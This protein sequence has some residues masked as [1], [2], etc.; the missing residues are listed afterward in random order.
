VIAVSVV[1]A[2]RERSAFLARALASLEA[3][4]S[5]P[6]FEVVVADNGS[7]DGTGAVVAAALA[8]DVLA[9]Q[10]VVVPEPSRAAARNAGI[11]AARGNLVLFVDDDVS[12]PTHFVAAH[13]AAHGRDPFP[14]VVSGPIINVPSYDERPAPSWANYSGAFLC[15][16]NASVPRSALLAAGGFDERFNL[17]GWEDTELGL[18]L[19]RRDVRHVFAWG[20]YLWHIKPPESETLDVV[21]AKTTERAQM[22]ARLLQKENGWRARLATGAFRANLVRSALSAPAWLL[23]AYRALATD[24][25]R[26]PALRA[27]ARAQLL[28]GTYTSTLRRALAAERTARR[29]LAARRPEG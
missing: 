9:M 3:Q 12:L 23:P 24:P 6:A 7:R 29:E 10:S 17:Y 26:P 21:L 25:A 4:E 1:I 5:A 22:A 11:A 28:D 14:R 13:A 19:R 18:R 27:L 8:R 15:T 20:A 2:T 16:C